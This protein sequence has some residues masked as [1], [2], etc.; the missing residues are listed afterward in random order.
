MEAGKCGDRYLN[1]QTGMGHSRVK[2]TF[3]CARESSCELTGGRA[4]FAAPSERTA[5]SR[6]PWLYS[7]ESRSV[8]DLP[9]Y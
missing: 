9:R 5:C 6:C 4:V 2:T 8:A 7:R 1:G 3:A